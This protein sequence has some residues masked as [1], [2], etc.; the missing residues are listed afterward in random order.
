MRLGL[1]GAGLA[2]AG[3]SAALLLHR[4]RRNRRAAIRHL[5]AFSRLDHRDIH[6]DSTVTKVPPLEAGNSWHGLAESIGRAIRKHL[7]QLKETEHDRTA[8]E[9]RCRRATTRYERIKGILCGLADPILAIDDY[10]EV[11]LGQS[12]CGGPV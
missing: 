3:G 7:E 6:T 2:L 1:L 8:L 5:E 10:D 11:V 12:Q 9:I 4:T